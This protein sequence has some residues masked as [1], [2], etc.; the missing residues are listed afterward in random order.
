[1]EA[2]FT[3]VGSRNA[4][5]PLN[6]QQRLA[7]L[8]AVFQQ[9]LVDKGYTIGNATATVN[10][11][12]NSLSFSLQTHVSIN[13]DPTDPLKFPEYIAHEFRVLLYA[14]QYDVSSLTVD[15]DG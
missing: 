10:R 7:Y 12:Q 1:M 2:T 9:L 8:V 3:I 13:P 11:V 15:N 14:N 6:L 4:G 5:P